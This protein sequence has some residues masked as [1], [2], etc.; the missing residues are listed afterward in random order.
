MPTYQTHLESGLKVTLVDGES[1]Q[2]GS[3]QTYI[4]LKGQNLKEMDFAW[5]DSTANTLWFLEL[6]DF[7]GLSLEEQ[8]PDDFV[9]NLAKKATDVLLML[10]SVWVNS[11]K[12]QKLCS[13]IVSFCP[14]F[15]TTLRKLKLVF[16]VKL[17]PHHQP[18]V[19]LDPLQIKLRN[20]LRGCLSLFD[21]KINNVL[22]IDSST[23][24]SSDLP[25]SL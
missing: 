20:Y 14:V 11:A 8:L 12:G 18:Q 6:K 15:P 1:F 5:W 21:I 19:Y 24:I 2:L 10:S 23:A 16:V 25:I 4:Q 3:C 9:K 7:S 22:L 17:G 13:E